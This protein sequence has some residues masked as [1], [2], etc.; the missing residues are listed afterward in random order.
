M[1]CSA[2]AHRREL[3]PREHRRR[4]RTRRRQRRRPVSCTTASCAAVPPGDTLAGATP[5]REAARRGATPACSSAWPGDMVHMTS[6]VPPGIMH[7]GLRRGPAR[8]HA[9]RR[10]HRGV[11]QPRRWAAPWLCSSAS[12]G[13]GG[14]VALGQFGRGAHRGD[15]S[16]AWG[17][18][19]WGS[20]GRLS[21]R[22]S[23][24]ARRPFRG[25]A[26]SARAARVGARPSPRRLTEPRGPS[27]SEMRGPSGSEACRSFQATG[28]RRSSGGKWP[29]AGRR[30]KLTEPRGP[31]AKKGGH[32]EANGQLFGAVAS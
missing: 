17:A 4:H 30:G 25:D 12:V 29:G 32:G 15:I 2:A 8:R 23:Q 31:A 24:S 18:A 27:G 9:L 26:S 3:A 22:S 14:S 19:A 5:W 28:A 13:D 1:T 6:T 10:L 20:P 21:A 11:K 16:S 7:D